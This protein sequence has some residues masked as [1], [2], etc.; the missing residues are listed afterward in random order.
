MM[1]IDEQLTQL[2][3]INAVEAPPF[4]LSSIKNRILEL[5]AAEAP[6]FWKLS[7]AACAIMVTCFNLFLLL[8]VNK[9]NENAKVA[10]VVSS[11]KLSDNNQ[12]YNE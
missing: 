10:T 1:N 5:K 11:L 12:L 9:S 4:L 6:V 7:F 8:E 3:Q 2:K